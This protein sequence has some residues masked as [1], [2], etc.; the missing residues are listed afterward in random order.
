MA[1]CTATP[2][3]QAL[4]SILL[5]DIAISKAKGADEWIEAYTDWHE[6]SQ[7]REEIASGKKAEK[8]LWERKRMRAEDFFHLDTYESEPKPRNER[9]A[10]QQEKKEVIKTLQEHVAARTSAGDIDI[11]PLP[12]APP[13][14]GNSTDR[15]LRMRLAMKEE[16]LVRE[17]KKEMS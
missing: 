9:F 7:W 10:L 17:K 6:A 1:Q 15:S 13:G 4:R 2:I 12:R 5:A 3:Q 16:R 11:G 8:R 14:T